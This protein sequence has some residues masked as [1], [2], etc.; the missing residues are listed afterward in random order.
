MLLNQ[1]IQEISFFRHCDVLIVSGCFCVKY[2]RGLL[3]N[4]HEKTFSTKNESSDKL[5]PTPEI[6]I[7]PHYCEGITTMH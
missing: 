2:Y 3:I 7:K 5:R 6:Q 1:L 4:T